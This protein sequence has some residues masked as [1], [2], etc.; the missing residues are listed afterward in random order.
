MQNNKNINIKTLEIS[1][2]GFFRLWLDFLK[3]FHKL[4]NKEIEVLSLLL[5]KRY[6]LKKKISDNAIVDKYL[7]DREIREEI[8]KEMGYS[9]LQVLSNML[10]DLRK[11]EVII[12]D[13]INS[14]LIPNLENGADNF[15]LMFNFKIKNEE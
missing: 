8:T 3:P 4:R 14:V 1:E 13:R 12:N 15:R 11:S 9:S 10:T 7:F 2:K 6:L 5:Y